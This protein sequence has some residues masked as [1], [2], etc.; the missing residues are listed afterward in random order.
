MNVFY[1]YFIAIYPGNSSKRFPRNTQTL[2][3]LEFLIQKI[4]SLKGSGFVF[5]STRKM[6]G[7]KEK[8]A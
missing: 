6:V 3:S 2:S 4:V 8:L 1:L 5:R 7:G